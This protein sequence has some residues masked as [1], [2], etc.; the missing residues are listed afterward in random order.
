MFSFAVKHPPYE[1][2][3]AALRGSV[4]GGRR[5]VLRHGDN[6]AAIGSQAGSVSL[7][8]HKCAG[9]DHRYLYYKYKAV[10]ARSAGRAQ[11]GRPCR[12][13]IIQL[14]YASDPRRR[15]AELR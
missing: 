7:P 11:A 12:P 2:V 14:A 5:L 8:V 1:G 13:L 4:Q 15:L 3:D 6:G 9:A 10:E